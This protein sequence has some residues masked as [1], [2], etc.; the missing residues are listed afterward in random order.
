MLQKVISGAPR[1]ARL[2]A[3]GIC[4]EDDTY[5]PI[6]A[7]SKELTVQ[8]V[9]GYSPGEFNETLR[10]ISEGVY[11]VAPLI[12]AN[13]GMDGVAGAFLELEKPDVHAKIMLDPTRR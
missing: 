11:D 8:F 10:R 1:E 9:L 13:V 4:A 5:R 7:I 2:V 6:T 3:V 12:T